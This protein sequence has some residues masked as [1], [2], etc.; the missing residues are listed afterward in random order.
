MVSELL[1]RLTED[2]RVEIGVTVMNHS[3]KLQDEALNS[4]FPD[5]YL[6]EAEKYAIS[7]QADASKRVLARPLS[8]KG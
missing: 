8:K 1:S 3:I 4:T 7:Q 6:R 2:E 5:S